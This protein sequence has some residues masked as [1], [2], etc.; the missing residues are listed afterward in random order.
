VIARHFAVRGYPGEKQVE[1]RLW[2]LAEAA[3][4]AK[5][6]EAYTQGLMDLGADVCT[7]KRPSCPSCPLRES[8]KARAQGKPEDDPRPRPRKKRPVKAASMLLLLRDGEVL[9]E[10]RPPTGVWGG[11]WCFPEAEPR[12]A[13]LAGKRRLP[14]LRHEFTHFT[15]DIAPIL[16]FLD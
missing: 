10:K 12:A 6:I 4:P 7:R 5:G 13:K 2:A 15:L 8:C 11:L 16:C 14:V 1:R 3:L 9:L